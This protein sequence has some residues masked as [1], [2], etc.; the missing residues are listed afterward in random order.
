MD[1]N[2]LT[3]KTQDGLQSAVAWVAE[4]GQQAVRPEHLLLALCQDKD[5][6]LRTLLARQGVEPGPVIAELEE[7]CRKHPRVSGDNAQVF[8]DREL[9]ALLASAARQAEGFGDE[10]ISSEHILLA[11]LEADRPAAGPFGRRGMGRDRVLELLKELRGGQRVDQPD[12]EQRYQA[13]ERYTTDLCRKARE[14]K[15]DPIIGREEEIRRVLQVLARRSKNNPVLIGDPGVGKTAIVEG[16]AQRI[17]AGEVP[18]SMKQQRLLSLDLGALIAGAKFRGEFEDRLKAVLNEVS[19]A[20][21]RVFLFIDELHTVVG[22]G[23]AEGSMDASN[24]LKP[25]L[26]RGELRCIG[27]TTT[28]EYRKYIEKDAALERRFQ[29][30]IVGEPDVE[31][32]LS[33]L[34]G[35]QERYEI[36]HGIRIRDGALVAAAEL[37]ARYIGDRR[38]PD[39]AIDLVDEAASRRRME[40]DSLPEALN[41]AESRVR[42]LEMEVRALARETDPDSAQRLGDC[43]RELQDQR[44][45]SQGL[46]ARWQ[47]EKEGLEQ[48]RSLKE[49]VERTRVELEQ[50]ERAGEYDRAAELKHGVLHA[51]KQRLEQQEQLQARRQAEGAVVS[52]E[53]GAA[54]VA[55]VVSRWT[56]IPV[57]RLLEDEKRKLASLEQRLGL[58]VIGQPA[59][60]EAVSRAIRRSRSGLADPDR[61]AGCFLFVG[62]SGV[63]K[64]ELARSLALEL[65]DDRDNLIRLDMSEYME[66]HSV[67]R[68]IGA[69]PGYIGHEEGGQLTEAL[70]R[71][72]FSVLLFDEV[73]KAHPE[74][75]DVLLQVMDEGRLTDSRGRTVDARHSILILTS[76]LG[77]ARLRDLLEE[78]GPAAQ[79][80]QRL[81]QEVE[82]ALRGALRPEFLNR[83]DEVIV[84]RPLQR[85]HERAIV[86]L[87]L[88]RVRRQLA[89]RHLELELSPAALDR[90]CELGFDPVYGARPVK[91]LLQ[92]EVV[93]RLALA[94]MEGHL[95]DGSR[96]RF[97][98]DGQQ[99][100]LLPIPAGESS[101]EKST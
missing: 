43:E 95:E 1:P 30:V 21:G 96:W 54:E 22:A 49:Q 13:L 8:M 66:K 42:R 10:Y 26:A 55:D 19:H 18:E 57:S 64:T 72:P 60:V 45:H 15:L 86:L 99:F 5:G 88:E 94:M 39:K 91:R 40:I 14:G 47:Q 27:A 92:K 56:R 36:H 78:G 85:E 51:L 89:G 23:A 100:T 37:S 44:R 29:P 73:E 84:F 71:R 50:A 75:L 17:V 11:A 33:I 12:A 59:A 32:T 83:L 82:Q 20:E 3:H 97:D 70:R 24:L 62:S 46:R 65:F 2:K 61:P 74:V 79:V 68:L 90:L 76:N 87:Q 98:L 34:R 81:E 38:L 67:S 28:A 101:Q 7:L 80:Q 77:S 6:V 52:E 93:D 48:I 58:R 9:Q 63:G 16:I 69:P 25:M 35:L 31:A 41:E 53:I 4:A